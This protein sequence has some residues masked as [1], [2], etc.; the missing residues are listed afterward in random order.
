MNS[1]FSQ[2]LARLAC[3][4]KIVT[5]ARDIVVASDVED[6]YGIIEV[7]IESLGQ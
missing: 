5:R 1:R 3:K 6:F 7:P 4:E 2:T